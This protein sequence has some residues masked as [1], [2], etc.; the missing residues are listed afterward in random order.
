[1]SHD[2]INGMAYGCGSSN[3]LIK[4]ST[5]STTG[6]ASLTGDESPPVANAYQNK[7]K[8]ANKTATSRNTKKSEIN[9]K[10]N[11]Y[12]INNLLFAKLNSQKANTNTALLSSGSQATSSI[13]ESLASSIGGTLPLQQQQPLTT[14]EDAPI[15]EATTSHLVAQQGEN[16]YE[17]AINEDDLQRKQQTHVNKS[18]FRS[19]FNGMS[20][21]GRDNIG[22][23][24]NGIGQNIEMKL[25]ESFYKYDSICS[26]TNRDKSDSV[27]LLNNLDSNE[28][29]FKYNTTSSV[30]TTPN[31][32]QNNYFSLMPAK[33]RTPQLNTKTS[34]STFVPIQNKQHHLE[35]DDIDESMH[36]AEDNTQ[37]AGEVKI[38]KNFFEIFN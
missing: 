37:E 14:N 3:V 6:G 11:K 34:T 27:I 4:T 20:S 17:T 26:L 7:F 25:R 19:D 35:A 33:N 18:L 36:T 21:F 28:G 24:S 9:L 29:P 30:R 22:K 23:K 16:L 32:P 31:H 13:C 15:G 12:T 1:M 10:K 5:Q 38:V 2:A 8:K